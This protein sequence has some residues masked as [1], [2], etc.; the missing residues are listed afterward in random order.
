MLGLSGS[1]SDGG[2]AHV[3]PPRAGNAASASSGPDTMM[4]LVVGGLA[5]LAIA[6]SGAPTATAAA[7]S[8]LLVPRDITPGTYFAQ[9]QPG[10]SYGYFAVCGDYAC[11]PDYGPNGCLL[12]TSPSPRDGLLSRMPS[13]A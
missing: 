3:Q 1:P 8:Y 13:S 6:L 9:I 12:Y 10:Y 11:D 7:E 2:T 4:R 5:S